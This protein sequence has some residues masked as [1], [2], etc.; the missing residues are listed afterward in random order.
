MAVRL[1]CED[2]LLA[3]VLQV[4]VQTSGEEILVMIVLH[5]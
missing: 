1:V 5:S 4:A 2:L 3:M